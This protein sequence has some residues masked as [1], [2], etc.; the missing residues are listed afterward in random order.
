MG[1]PFSRR[2]LIRLGLLAGAGIQLADA[3][4]TLTRKTIPS[5]GE[6]IPVVGLGTNAYGVSDA[7]ELEAR[8]AVLKRM[9]EVGASVV[10]TAPAYGDSEKVLG[11]FLTQL[12]IHDRMFLATKITAAEGER[13]PGKAMF[14]ASLERLLTGRI[15][16]LQVHSLKGVDPLMPVLKEWKAAKR[17]RYLGVTT[18]RGEQHEELLATM[19]R[20][21][22]DFIQVNYSIG[23]RAA[24]A[25]ILPLAAE[26]G[27]AVLLNL[28]FGGRRGSLFA[29]TNGRALPAFAA[30]L[31][32]ASWGQFFLKYVI[33]HPA[34]TCAIPGTTKISHLDDNLGAARGALP[35]AALRKKMEATWDALAS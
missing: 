18:S 25:K 26:R 14:E 3:G 4:E 23:D 24:A 28:P 33:S 12:G 16:L 6:T 5:S 1:Q 10:D 11:E 8:R 27:V 29:Q 15:D 30:E 9:S 20:H 22:L 19:A 21:P 17:I 32:I 2:D 35:D 13:D 7:G 31:G 34:V